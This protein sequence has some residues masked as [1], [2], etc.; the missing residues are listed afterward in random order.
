VGFPVDGSS[1]QCSCGGALG[2]ANLGVISPKKGDATHCCFDQIIAAAGLKMELSAHVVQMILPGTLP[3]RHPR[4]NDVL[5]KTWQGVV[6]SY[7]NKII[8]N[9]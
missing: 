1:W 5:R 7:R 6:S 4:S 2:V 8:R 9:S 3:E